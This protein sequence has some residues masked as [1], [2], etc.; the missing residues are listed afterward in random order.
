MIDKSPQVTIITP[1]HNGQNFLETFFDA[2]L[3]QTTSFKM[4]IINDAS[5]D[6]T[7]KILNKFQ[8]KMPFEIKIIK[9][10]DNIGPGQSRFKAISQVDTEYLAFCDIDDIWPANKLEVQLKEVNQKRVKWSFHG[11]RIFINNKFSGKTVEAINIKTMFEVLSTR[12]I[13][14]SSIL[15]KS[16][17]ASKLPSLEGEYLGEDYIWWSYLMLY[18]GPPLAIKNLYYDYY[19]HAGSSSKNKF[20][21][22]IAIF[23]IYFLRNVI[24][25]SRGRGLLAFIFYALRSLAQVLKY[26]NENL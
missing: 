13:G 20:K 26:K 19:V 4:I 9:E 23:D 11:R 3:K 22:A 15:I 6:D 25:V 10:L 21:M 12:S 16:N 24:P 1:I 2:L 7:E 8:K 17:L 18:A 14:L 5:T